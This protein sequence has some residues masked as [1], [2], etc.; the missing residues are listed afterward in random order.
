MNI[1]QGN[2]VVVGA[3]TKDQQVYW[4]GAKVEGIVGLSIDNNEKRQRVVV[5]VKD[6]PVLAEM[7]A[8]GIKVRRVK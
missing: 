5:T 4:N 2:L 3:N 7:A 1:G 8:A 6:D